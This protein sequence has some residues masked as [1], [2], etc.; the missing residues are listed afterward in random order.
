M[1]KY[2]S[3]IVKIEQSIPSAVATP[4]PPK[5]EE[6]SIPSTQP[7]PPPNKSPGDK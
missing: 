3:K 5:R 4:P 2:N 7:T 6:R 1:E